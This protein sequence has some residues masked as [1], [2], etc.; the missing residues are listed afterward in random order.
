MPYFLESVDG[1]QR[2]NLSGPEEVYLVGRIEECDIRLESRKVSR[3]HCCLAQ[4]N[5]YLAVRDLGSTNGIR[6]NGR[7]VLE[8]KLYNGDLLTIGPYKFRVVWQPENAV[9]NAAAGV[10]SRVSSMP[11][12]AAPGPT[13]RPL[14][15]SPP[16]HSPPAAS[17]KPASLLE[18][19]E[20]FKM[21]ESDDP[22]LGGKR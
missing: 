5:D 9:R 21:L 22:L 13:D 1:E 3:R 19:S 11:A 16:A 12:P 7:E 2:F 10:P 17:H 18:N 15:H 4:V 6:I 20:L 14:T 8:G